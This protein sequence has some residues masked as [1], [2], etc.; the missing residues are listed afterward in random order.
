[1]IR[2][3]E[4]KLKLKNMFDFLFPFMTRLV[5][6][7]S[8]RVVKTDV[9][10]LSSC[11]TG[12]VIFSGKRSLGIFFSLELEKCFRFYISKMNSTQE[13]EVIYSE[14]HPLCGMIFR[15][16]FT[17]VLYPVWI[18]LWS[19]TLPKITNFLFCEYAHIVWK[20]N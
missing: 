8:L 16:K 14:H 13:V 17:D 19:L 7:S 18:K 1:M 6:D 2:S 11:C 12:K 9:L 20:E 10:S 5:P 3:S 15:Y 4:E